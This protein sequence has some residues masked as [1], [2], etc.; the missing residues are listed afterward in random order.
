MKVDLS[1]NSRTLLMKHDLIGAVL[2]F[3]FFAITA[4]FFCP[5]Q[6]MPCT[7]FSLSLPDGRRHPGLGKQSQSLNTRNRAIAISP[8][9]HA[10]TTMF[11]Q[12]QPCDAW[13]TTMPAIISVFG[14]CHPHTFL[15]SHTPQGMFKESRSELEQILV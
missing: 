1:T 13:H 6:G 9:V 14:V 5:C 12:P 3:N 10:V 11:S 15:R 2:S 7:S 8:Y 4:S